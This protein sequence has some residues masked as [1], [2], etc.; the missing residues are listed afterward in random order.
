MQKS[1]RDIPFEALGF[2]LLGGT[3]ALL[4]GCGGTSNQT[5]VQADLALSAVDEPFNAQ[6]LRTLYRKLS[7]MAEPMRQ[8][9]VRESSTLRV[10]IPT[11][12]GEEV[13]HFALVRNS[14]GDY[15]HLRIT[16]PKT[17][18]HVNF[19]FGGPVAQGVTLRLTD[20]GSRLLQRDGQPLVFRLF[21]GEPR[22]RTPQ[23]WITTGIQIAAL[24]FLVWIGAV[25]VRGVAAAVGFVAFNLIVLGALAAGL[26][27]AIPV[28][29][30]FLETS[31]IDWDTVR[32]FVEQTAETIIELLREVTR[33]LTQ[34]ISLYR[35]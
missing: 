21:G 35:G 12:Q 24:A 34:G 1:N 14:A 22:T 2:A 27:V 11:A 3:L 17:G 10:Q 9:S 30:W 13:L 5:P 32:R 33:W 4:S 25:V 29:R 8:R 18:E 15:P 28:I 23:D 7:T 6:R 19:V 16:R 26:G 31:G 20:D